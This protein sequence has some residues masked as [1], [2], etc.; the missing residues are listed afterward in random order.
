MLGELSDLDDRFGVALRN[1]REQ[2]TVP[3]GAGHGR[4]CER[5]RGAEQ[6]WN[7]MI[8]EASDR[9]DAAASRQQRSQP[10]ELASSRAEP[11]QAGRRHAQVECR[12]IQ[13][14]GHIWSIAQAPSGSAVIQIQPPR[15]CAIPA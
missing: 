4:E 5:G 10:H 14:T 15:V 3:V 1:Q 13:Q 7:P 11:L 8:G 12:R 9:E 2:Q 6:Q